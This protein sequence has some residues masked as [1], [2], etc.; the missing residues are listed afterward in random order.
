MDNLQNDSL[1]MSFTSYGANKSPTKGSKN[2]DGSHVNMSADTQ[3]GDISN[4]FNP[5]ESMISTKSKNGS[6]GSKKRRMS[7]NNMFRKQKTNTAKGKKESVP[8]PNVFQV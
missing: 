3:K 8:K 1:L 2:S 7:I 5:N 4:S 6:H